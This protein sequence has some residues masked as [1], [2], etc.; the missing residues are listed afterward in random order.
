MLCAADMFSSPFVACALIT[1]LI[2]SLV[3]TSKKGRKSS[4]VHSLGRRLYNLCPPIVK[5]VTPAKEDMGHKFKI[6]MPHLL[7]Q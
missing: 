3:M 6:C 5:V 7:C 2:D 4:F 1:L